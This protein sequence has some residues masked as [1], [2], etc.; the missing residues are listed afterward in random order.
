MHVVYKTCFYEIAVFNL[1]S[2]IS[3]TILFK[4]FD[5][6]KMLTCIKGYENISILKAC[7]NARKS[8]NVSE[9]TILEALK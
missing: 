4:N 7:K 6:D 8:R 2:L 5:I 3:P 1:N 9:E